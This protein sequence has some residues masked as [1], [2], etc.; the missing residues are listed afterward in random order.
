MRNLNLVPLNGLRALEAVG[1]LG[2]LQAAAEELGVTIGAVSQQVIKA[3]DQ[4]G[5]TVFERLPKGMQPTPFGGPFLARLTASFRQMSEAVATAQRRDDAI[6]TISVA[7][8]FASRWLIHRIDRFSA[9]HPDISLRI[10]AVSTLVD[11]ARSDVDLGIRVGPGN[12]PDVTAEFLMPQV[13][14][15]VCAPS[16]AEKLKRPEDLTQMPAVIDG[17]DAFTWERWL[18]AAGLDIAAPKARHVFS[19]ASLCLDAALSGQ[20]VLLAWPILASWALKEGR[21]VA[22]FPTC[23]DTGMGYY[24]VTAPGQRDPRKV[25]VFKAWVRHEMAKDME[26]GV[27]PGFTPP[28]RAAPPSSP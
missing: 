12:W 1:R 8:I 26:A 4:L 27:M 15:P 7:P 19:D 14:F 16:I 24:F 18:L 6:L 20:G 22:P 2:S 25:T 11:V 3:E 17:N 10:E 13:M 9:V 28:R 23:V 5:R 21:L